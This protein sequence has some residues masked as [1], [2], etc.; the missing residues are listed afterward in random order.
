MKLYVFLALLATA[1]AD[2][3]FET[4]CTQKPKVGPCIAKLRRW[5]FNVE[6]GKCE[7]FNYGGCRGNENRYLSQK[8]CKMTCMTPSALAHLYRSGSAASVT[9]AVQVAHTKSEDALLR[10]S[11]CSRPAHRGPCTRILSRTYYDQKTGTC[12]PFSYGGCGSNNNNFWSVEDC[13]RFC[14]SVKSGQKVD[15][16]TSIGK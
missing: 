12:L 5:W 13:M 7:M 11:V 14:G 16:S 3:K 8:E 9:P 2:T 1:L 10:A 4:R 15:A 6:T